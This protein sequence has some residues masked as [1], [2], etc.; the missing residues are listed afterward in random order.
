MFIVYDDKENCDDEYQKKMFVTNAASEP[1]GVDPDDDQGWLYRD[2]SYIPMSA[3]A[4]LTYSSV[5][6]LT[7]SQQC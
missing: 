4:Q 5:D 3:I 6:S 7:R 2:D 1:D